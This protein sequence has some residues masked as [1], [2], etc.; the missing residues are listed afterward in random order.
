MDKIKLIIFDL[1]GVLVEA[2]KIH[3]DTLNDAL[4]V[5]DD[6]YTISI[7]SLEAAEEVLEH[8]KKIIDNIKNKPL[9]PEV[10]INE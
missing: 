6:K 2:K 8:M 7:N 10:A 5:I 4:G 1:D 9:L 3:Y